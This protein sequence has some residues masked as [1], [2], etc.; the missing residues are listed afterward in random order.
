MLL[1]KFYV[2][3]FVIIERLT[4]YHL[5]TQMHLRTCLRNFAPCHM[6]S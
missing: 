5:T 6:V 4:H 2:E 1:T 3:V